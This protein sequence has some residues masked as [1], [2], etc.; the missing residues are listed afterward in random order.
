MT[1]PNRLYEADKM[2]IMNEAK[3]RTAMKDPA[4]VER[5]YEKYISRQERYFTRETLKDHR[6]TYWQLKAWM[7]EGRELLMGREL[8]KTQQRIGRLRKANREQHRALKDARQR[9]KE[10]E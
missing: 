4:F 7:A 2:R 9:I 10:L 5:E 6:I 1:D 8:T 3:V